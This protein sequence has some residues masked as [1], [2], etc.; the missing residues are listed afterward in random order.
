MVYSRYTWVDNTT[1]VNATRM[2]ALEGAAAHADV[3]V[4]SF[5]R[6]LSTASGTQAITGVGFEPTAV[7]F[8]AIVDTTTQTSWGMD[9]GTISSANMDNYGDTANTY[10]NDLGHSIW[11]R[12]NATNY[13]YAKITSL[14]SDGFTLTWV[15]NNSPTGTATIMYMAFR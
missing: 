10:R 15:K 12:P 2:N 13:S 3:K 9:D 5:T 11:L 6:D 4:G 8:F 1:V 14:D 7:M